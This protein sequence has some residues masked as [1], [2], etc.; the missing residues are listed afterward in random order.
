MTYS[1]GYIT[2]PRT[3]LYYL[4][5]QVSCDASNWCGHSIRVNG[6]SITVHE[7][8]STQDVLKFQTIV[9]GLLRKL[10]GGD[11]LSVIARN[12]AITTKSF[13]GAVWLS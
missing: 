3:G 5:A 9:S 4:Y 8:G 1:S 10:N 12:S 11:K 2:V 7:H 6:N 13:F